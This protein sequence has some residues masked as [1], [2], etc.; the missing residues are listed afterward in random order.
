M[1]PPDT[2]IKYEWTT[3]Y[4]EVRGVK[5]LNAL[6]R[7]GWRFVAVVNGMPTDARYLMEKR[8]KRATYVMMTSA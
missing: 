3:E 5:R 1:N 8:V 2:R 6:T 4:R 7:E